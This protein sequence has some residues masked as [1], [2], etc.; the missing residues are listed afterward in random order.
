VPSEPIRDLEHHFAIGGRVYL[1]QV[2]DD[3]VHSAAP[4]ASGDSSAA[5]VTVSITPGPS[6]RDWQ[7]TPQQIANGLISQTQ[8]LVPLPVTDGDWQD[9][10]DRVIH[11]VRQ[12]RG[13]A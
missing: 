8:R 12:H 1:L 2:C 9:V 7:L 11:W 13:T 10:R 4:I 3:D 6:L 5:N